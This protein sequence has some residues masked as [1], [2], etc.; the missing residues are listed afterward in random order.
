LLGGGLWD[1]LEDEL[2]MV[3]SLSWEWFGNGLMSVSDGLLDESTMFVELMGADLLD[4]S[5]V[6][7]LP[8]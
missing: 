2:V 3:C 1:C 6:S 7:S 4:V 8:V 5:L